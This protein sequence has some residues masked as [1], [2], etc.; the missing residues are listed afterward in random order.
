V[1]AALVALVAS[2]AGAPAATAAMLELRVTDRDGQPAADVVVLVEVPTAAVAAVATL[3]PAETATIVQQGSRFEPA[4]TVVRA[5][6]SVR[7]VNHDSY[8]HHLRSVPSG[9]LANVPPARQ[10][11]LRQGP[12]GHRRKADSPPAVNEERFDVPGPVGLGCHLHSTMRGHIYVSA[13][14]H[15]GKTD[16]Q[17]VVRIT[18]LPEGRATLRLWHAEQLLEQPAQPLSLGPATLAM[19]ASLNFNPPPPRR[20]RGAGG[21]AG[22]AL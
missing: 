15:F 7:F 8:D 14:P 21:G 3:P 4:L 9:P 5:G 17:G 2:A 6:S 11:E 18:G 22:R 13:T 10:F 1:F 12:A 20:A 16:D 19:S